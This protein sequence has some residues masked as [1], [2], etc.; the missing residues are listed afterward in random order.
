[1]TPL[2][3]LVDRTWTTDLSPRRFLSAALAT[4]S[5]MIAGCTSVEYRTVNKQHIRNNAGHII[6]YSAIDENPNTKER[7]ERQVQ[8]NPIKNDQGIVERYEEPTRYGA[9]IRDTSGNKIGER[10]KDLRS[11]SDL[12]VVILGTPTRSIDKQ[13]ERPII[14]S[15]DAP[16]LAP[17]PAAVNEKYDVAQA[18]RD[19]ESREGALADFRKMESDAFLAYR[20]HAQSALS[21]RNQAY[22]DRIRYETARGILQRDSNLYLGS[23]LL[24][25]LEIDRTAQAK[26]QE[27]IAKAKI[28]SARIAIEN[29]EKTRQAEQARAALEKMEQSRRSEEQRLAKL[30]QEADTK[31]A[32]EALSNLKTQTIWQLAEHLRLDQ[33]NRVEM[34]KISTGRGPEARILP[35]APQTPE[36][37][38][39]AVV[40]EVAKPIDKLTSYTGH[41]N[42]S[43]KLRELAQSYASNPQTS[44]LDSINAIL[45]SQCDA[46][47]A[48]AVTYSAP[49][50]KTLKGVI[51]AL[52]P[53][54]VKKDV[55]AKHTW[56]DGTLINMASKAN[57][58]F[59]PTSTR[60]EGDLAWTQVS[61]TIVTTMLYQTTPTIEIPNQRIDSSQ[62]HQGN[63]H[64][65]PD[66]TGAVR[67]I[68]REK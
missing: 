15:S 57:Q 37:R 24:Q 12:T 14:T 18:K 62:F 53:L 60:Q 8:F 3:T 28:E 9:I 40:A 16:K 32:Q 25:R 20:S 68:C 67:A 46:A 27:S 49:N 63:A 43:L 23:A 17:N 11:G 58:A 22:Q 26:A 13:Q 21:N 44:T 19:S 34:G 6:G 55:F 31:A 35:P 48:V 61:A 10:R 51:G 30:R 1:M 4:A 65:K 59:N 7:I 29:A 56:D 33:P 5:L 2:Q 38:K 42:P 54:Y 45:A 47:V 36:Y 41:V 66:R 52:S 64:Y 39:P 50:G